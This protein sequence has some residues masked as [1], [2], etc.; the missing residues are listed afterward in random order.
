MQIYVSPPYSSPEKIRVWL[1][2]GE[3]GYGPVRVEADGVT[4]ETES[5]VRIGN[6]FLMCPQ[7]G[8]TFLVFDADYASDDFVTFVFELKDRLLVECDRREGLSIDTVNTDSLKGRMHLD[9]LGT[10]GGQ[11]DYTPGP[12]G[13]LEASGSWYEIPESGSPWQDLHVVRELPVRI[14]EEETTLPAGSVI[15]ITA[16]DD[17][18][19]VRFREIGRAHV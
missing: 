9:M 8:R 3:E 2:G 5:F 7:D 10:Y 6:I 16:A 11:M 13:Q 15:R 17:E 1:D 12:D 18:G 19:T 4:A 14:G